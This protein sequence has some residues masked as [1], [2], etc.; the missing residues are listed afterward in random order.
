MNEQKGKAACSCA[1]CACSGVAP[2][3]RV[4][5]GEAAAGEAQRVSVF[6]IPGMDCPAEEQIIRLAL[7]DVARGLAFELGARRLEVWHDEPAE[8]LL[9]RL[10]KLG[11]GAELLESGTPAGEGAPPEA[12]GPAAERHVLWL[13]LAINALMFVVEGLAG[14]WAESSGLLADGLD[15]FADA[16][17]YGAALYAVGRG[18]LAQLKAARLAGLLQLV[19]A[20]GLFA[21]VGV[22]VVEGAEPLGLPMMLVAALALLANL[23][24]LLLIARH[25]GGGVHMKASYIF[26]GTDVLANLGVI[27]A[28][29]LVA[30]SGL[31]FP[32]WVVGG[33]IGAMVL[34]G[35]VRILRLG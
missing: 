25:K 30:W 10:R 6:R 24:C 33:L 4:S 26:S 1:D 19:L 35:A 21:Q 3:V 34:V 27:L 7:R 13:L 20:L 22:H 31:P 14:W 12:T 8:Q 2:E 23:A 18:A 17:V 28:G 16:A 11:M 15:M 9:G 32:D 5:A 29:G